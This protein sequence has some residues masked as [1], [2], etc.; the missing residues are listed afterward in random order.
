MI[1][2]ALCAASF[3]VA[4]LSPSQSGAQDLADIE[5]PEPGEYRATITFQ[6][7]DMPGAPPQMADMMSRMMSNTVTYCLT[8]AEIEEGFKAITDRST[9]EGQ[10]CSYE[11]FNHTGGEIDAVMI[12]NADGRDIRMEMTG[13]GGASASDFTMKMS[14]DFGMGDGSMTLRAQ[15]E[16]LGA[17]S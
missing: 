6:S 8:E 7:I 14:G 2:G 10:E 16:R 15:H 13:T 3:V 12:C 9:Q 17:C 1:G 5:R 11:R 4:A